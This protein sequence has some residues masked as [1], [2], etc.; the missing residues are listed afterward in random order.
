MFQH[1]NAKLVSWHGR[2]LTLLRPVVISWQF[3]SVH[4][5]THNPQVCGFLCTF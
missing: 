3:V 4:A 2:H 1:G 5:R